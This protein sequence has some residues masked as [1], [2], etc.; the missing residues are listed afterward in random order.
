MSAISN[1]AGDI[2]TD[3]IDILKETKRFYA[4]LYTAETGVGPGS[5]SGFSAVL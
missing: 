1:S 5:G 2:L 4:Q 3:P